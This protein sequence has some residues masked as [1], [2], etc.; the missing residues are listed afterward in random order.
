MYIILW[1]K[2]GDKHLDA[3]KNED[4]SIKLFDILGEADLYASK[5]EQ[6]RGNKNDMRVISIEGVEE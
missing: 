3:V 1:W 5:S 6:L 4:G 2:N